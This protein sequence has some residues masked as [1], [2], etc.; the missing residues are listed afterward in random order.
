[1]IFVTTYIVSQAVISYICKNEQISTTDGFI[2][3][4]LGLSGTKAGTRTLQKKGI[5]VIAVKVRCNLEILI[6]FLAEF[7]QILIYSLRHIVA[8]FQRNHF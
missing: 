6:Y 2:E 7:Y 3:N 8:A 4:S 5:F 1:M